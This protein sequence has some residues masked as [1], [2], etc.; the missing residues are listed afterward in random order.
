M[1]GYEAFLIISALH[2][3]GVG[4]F[5]TVAHNLY[6]QQL[7]ENERTR[8]AVIVTV[9]ASVFWEITFILILRRKRK[10]KKDDK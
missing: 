4:I 7:P 3:I 6:L 9:L 5:Y 1:T 2:L 8:N 10:S